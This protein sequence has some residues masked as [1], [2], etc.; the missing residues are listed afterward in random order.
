MFC[1]GV[2]DA[3]LSEN[4]FQYISSMNWKLIVMGVAVLVT[5]IIVAVYYKKVS[6]MVRQGFQ[7]INPKNEFIMYYADWCPHCKTAMP[8]FDTFAGNGT[9]VVNG[10]DVS[11]Q[12]YEST[13]DAEKLKGKNIKGFPT[14]YLNT[15][16][17]KNIEYKGPRSSDEYL[18]FLN[19]NLGAKN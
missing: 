13:K 3:L 12:K 14:F 19:A 11:V 4:V 1:A 10:V 9:I 8:D 7:N 17:G 2:L 18:K 15:A 6:G 16:D 5:L